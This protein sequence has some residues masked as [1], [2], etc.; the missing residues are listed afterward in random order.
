MAPTNS[1]GDRGPPCVEA[2]PDGVAASGCANAQPAAGTGAAAAMGGATHGNLLGGLVKRVV[3]N[4]DTSA[5]GVT[6]CLDSVR[7]NPVGGI[8]E[9]RGLT[10]NNPHGYRSPYLLRAERVILEVDVQAM[11]LS[12]GARLDVEEVVFEGLEVIYEKSITTSNLGDLAARLAAARRAEAAAAAGAGAGGVVGAGCDV[13]KDSMSSDKKHLQVTL[14]RVLAR[15]VHARVVSFYSPL[16]GV[17]LDVGDVSYRDVDTRAGRERALNDVVRTL[18]ATLLRRV[19]AAAVGERAATALLGAVSR[20]S[21]GVVHGVGSVVRDAA[22]AMKLA[23]REALGADEA[24]WVILGDGWQ[25]MDGGDGWE[26]I[27]GGW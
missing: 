1:A 14:H 15:D 9:A 18:L 20:A 3:E 6:V 26:V 16:K 19:L 13:R 17:R 24:E 21:D 12:L 22:A 27:D 4:F 25:V 10:V 11:I 5:L 23:V 8:I 2:G 7:F